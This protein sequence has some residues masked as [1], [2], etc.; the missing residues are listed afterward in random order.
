F[1]E[2]EEAVTAARVALSSQV[3]KNIKFGMT[4]LGIHVP[5]RM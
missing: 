2:Q 4:L 1:G 3:A 5:D